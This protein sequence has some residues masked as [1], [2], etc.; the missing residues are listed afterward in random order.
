MY[1]THDKY[2]LP[3]A[4]AGSVKELAYMLKVK[5]TSISS[6]LSK[7]KRKGFKSRYVKVEIE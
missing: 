1:V 6:V 2:E 7:A 3:L 4:V 5:P